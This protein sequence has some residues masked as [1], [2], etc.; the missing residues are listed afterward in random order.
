MARMMTTTVVSRWSDRRPEPVPGKAGWIGAMLCLGLALAGQTGCSPT[1]LDGPPPSPL[2][3]VSGSDPV[4]EAF[5]V[6]VASGALTPSAAS[7]TPGGG[8]GFLAWSP[9]HRHLYA[10]THQTDRVLA[11][12]VDARTGA[13]TYLNDAPSGGRGPC[14]L[15]VDPS[16]RWV[17]TAQYT[18]G[19]IAVLPIAASGRVGDPVYRSVAGAW[20][21]EIVCDPSG[22][23][24]LVP[25]KGSDYIAQYRFDP[26]TGQLSPNSPA[27]LLTTPHAGPRHL[28]FNP[29]LTMAYVV[30]ELGN[31]VT[32]M[33]YDAAHGVLSE[34]QDLS[35]LPPGVS[36]PSTGAAICVSPD[37]AFVYASNRG[38][39]SI[40][41]YRVDANSGRLT[42]V[43]WET[44]GGAIRFPRDMCLDPSGRFL[45]VANQHGDTVV[46]FR[47]AAD[48]GLLSRCGQA[49]VPAGPSFVGIMAPAPDGA[50]PHPE[51]D[52]DRG[53]DARRGDLE[54]TPSRCGAI[55][56]GGAPAR[57]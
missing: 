14:F 36:T 15:T 20:A 17:L 25:C 11:F 53:D 26:A 44:G 4:I 3:F 45:L 46:V 23:F 1:V 49:T 37:G 38:H 10:V 42:T 54:R 31:S 55:N 30:N 19:I 43:G 21:H 39:D 18:S 56:R 6:D 12:A 33:H 5:H 48:S 50:V 52:R 13:L 16:G 51:G 8:P 57:P 35:S 27:R 32:S 34:P 24:V 7:R 41:I 40:A 22:R 28:A 2:A 29:A 9:D 47:R